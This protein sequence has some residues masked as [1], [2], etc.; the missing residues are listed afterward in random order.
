MRGRTGRWLNVITRAR[1]ESGWTRTEELDPADDAEPDDFGE[2]A[3]FLQWHATADEALL[4]QRCK[5]RPR[6]QPWSEAEARKEFHETVAHYWPD[7]NAEA[8]ASNRPLRRDA[9]PQPRPVL[10]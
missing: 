3:V 1:I 7:C 4:E 9:V 8:D 2:M 10:R 6:R 5:R